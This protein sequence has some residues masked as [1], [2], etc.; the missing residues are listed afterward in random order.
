VNLAQIKGNSIVLIG[1][2]NNAWTE[3][4]LMPLRFHFV[5]PPGE[6]IVDTWH[7]EKQ[8][9][10]DRSKPYSEAP[11]YGIVARFHDSSTDG[12]VVV[13][14]GLQRF[15]TDAASEFVVSSHFLDSLNRQIGS[16]WKDKNIEVVIRVDVVNGRAGAPITE[17][18]HT[19]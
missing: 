5:A 15:G 8:W 11:D 17:A 9:A 6:A 12:I 16:N 7:P 13:I 19:W 14:A 4:L 10:R 1:A 3:R 2:Y 18:I